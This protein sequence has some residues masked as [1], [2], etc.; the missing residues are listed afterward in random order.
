MKEGRILRQNARVHSTIDPGMD[1]LEGLLRSGIRNGKRI[2]CEKR[3]DD[4]TGSY[5]RVRINGSWVQAKRCRQRG[6]GKEVQAK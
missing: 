4:P 6:A 5:K 1:Q 2:W 3:N